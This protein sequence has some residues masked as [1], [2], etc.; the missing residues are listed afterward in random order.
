MF[1][2]YFL[3]LMLGEKDCR[4]GVMKYNFASLEMNVMRI[5]YWLD[6]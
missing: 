5:T 1:I 2:T 3:F 4:E 6:F